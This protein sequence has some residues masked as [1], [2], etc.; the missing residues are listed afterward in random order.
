MTDSPAQR[1]WKAPNPD[2]RARIADA[3]EANR[4]MALIGASLGLVE[5]GVV[6]IRLAINE[7]HMSHIPGVVHGGTLGMIADSALGFAALSLA[8]A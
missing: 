5:P 4:A 8:A 2:F 1:I 6:E 3:F 7:M